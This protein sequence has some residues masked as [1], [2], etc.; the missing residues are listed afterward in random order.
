MEWST[1]LIV[2]VL[3]LPGGTLR[4]TSYNDAEYFSKHKRARKKLF[5]RGSVRGGDCGAESGAHS[6]RNHEPQRAIESVLGAEVSQIH[7][8]QES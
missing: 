4:A 2:W 1:H 7:T 5:L 3:Q 8:P 6:G